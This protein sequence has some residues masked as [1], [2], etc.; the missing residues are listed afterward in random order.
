MACC[1]SSLTFFADALTTVI[2]YPEA[3]KMLYGAKPRVNVYYYDIITH[4]FYT[5]NDFPG[6]QVIFNG[7][8]IEIDHGGLASGY[9]KIS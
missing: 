4:D 5:L 2:L 7:S 1:P 8:E 6:S 3:F 9:V